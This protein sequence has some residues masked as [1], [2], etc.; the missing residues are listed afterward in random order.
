MP[1]GARVRVRLAESAAELSQ[2]AA[3][4]REYAAS[5]AFAL[6]YQG[7]ESEVASLPGKYAPPQGC[8]LL[9]WV[10]DHAE[11][12]GCIAMRPL[13]ASGYR[14]GDPTPACEMKRM[15]VRPT[16]RG[17]GA[18]R[19]L[20]AELLAR[21]RRAGYAMMKLDTERTFLAATALYRELG[22]VEIPRYNDDPQPDTIWMGL[23]L[24]R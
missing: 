5:L 10:D 12:V 14:E 20:A 22:F 7:F 4:M 19:A 17:L 1:S 2:A 16:A 3:L 13:D 15:Y 24:E 8:I 9:A 18:G 23:V 6:D 11:P 21:A